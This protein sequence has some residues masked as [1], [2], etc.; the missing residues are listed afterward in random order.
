[1]PDS[2]TW[3]GKVTQT[4]GSWYAVLLDSGKQIQCRLRG[5]IKLQELDT[6]NPVAVGDWVMVEKTPE[7]EVY[8]IAEI[9]KR[10][11]YIIRQSPRKQ[12]QRHI[13]ASNID[14]F[15]IIAAISQPR[16]SLGFIDRCI[17]AAECY[18]IPLQ[19]IINKKDLLR[20]KDWEKLEEWL[21]IYRHIGY[22]IQVISA[23]DA[24]D[25]ARIKL[26]LQDKTTLVSGHSGVGKTTLLNA[27]NPALNLKTGKISDKWEKGMHVTTF[28][29]LYRVADNSF[30]IDTPGIKEFAILH[31]EPE[32]VSGYFIDINRF[33]KSCKYNNCMHLNEPECAVLHALENGKLAPSRYESYLNIV[34]N[35]KAINYWERK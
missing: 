9:L 5:K 24:A 34:E 10:N 8:V 15:F 4:T 20:K 25:I 30:V 18:H 21:A 16:T 6:T 28:A 7:E 23:N 26:L 22:P 27:V 32:E 11:N 12:H 35:I 29:T 31:L 3:R 19:I 17:A 13:I 1:M 33:A 2:H 14:Q